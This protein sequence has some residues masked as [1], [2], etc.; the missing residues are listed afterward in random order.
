MHSKPT[1]TG[2]RILYIFSLCFLS[3]ISFSFFNFSSSSYVVIFISS[4]PYM[5]G[6]LVN[7]AR[8]GSDEDVAV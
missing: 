5:T 2:S 6:G 7:G 3:Y 1:T 8:L 4:K